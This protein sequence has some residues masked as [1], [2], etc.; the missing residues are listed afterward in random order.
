MHTTPVLAQTFFISIII[1]EDTQVSP[2][3]HFYVKLGPKK[4][5]LKKSHKRSPCLF[6]YATAGKKDSG[7]SEWSC[8]LHQHVRMFETRIFKHTI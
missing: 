1:T 3:Q 8:Y 4:I 2:T 6:E 7:L 5:I